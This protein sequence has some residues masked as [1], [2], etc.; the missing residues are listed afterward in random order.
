MLGMVSLAVK[1]ELAM[2]ILRKF[3][4][5]RSRKVSIRTRSSLP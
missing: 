3:L 2:L 5:R 1:V 4:V